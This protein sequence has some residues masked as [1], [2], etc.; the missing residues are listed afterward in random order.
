M[1]YSA[2]PWTVAH[3]PP[4]PCPW[5]SQGSHLRLLNCRR[6]FLFV[7]FTTEPSGTPKNSLPPTQIF[8][9]SEIIPLIQ[10]VATGQIRDSPQDRPHLVGENL[11]VREELPI[12]RDPPRDHLLK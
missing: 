2:T 3:Q 7:C 6:V 11:P 9:S 12:R 5:D 8:Y 4:L 1:A 10:M